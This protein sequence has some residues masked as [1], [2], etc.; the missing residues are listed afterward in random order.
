M[1]RICTKCGGLLI[2]ELPMD[3]YQARHW[4]CVNYGWSREE[5]LVCPSRAISPLRHHVCR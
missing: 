3:F 2:G 1:S 4:K 5:P